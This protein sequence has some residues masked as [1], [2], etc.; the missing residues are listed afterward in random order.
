MR[1]LILRLNEKERNSE[2]VSKLQSLT[3]PI[4]FAFKLRRRMTLSTFLISSLYFQISK[5]EIRKISPNEQATAATK[6]GSYA[7]L[8]E[9]ELIGISKGN[10]IRNFVVKKTL[11]VL[12]SLTV[13]SFFIV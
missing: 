9:V 8:F 2:E 5:H 13:R 10:P 7:L 4:S 6:R 1:N 12:H 11:L 3:S